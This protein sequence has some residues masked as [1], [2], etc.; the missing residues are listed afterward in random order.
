[1][2]K[3][4][5]QFSIRSP[6]GPHRRLWVADSWWGLSWRLGASQS[7]SALSAFYGLRW[8]EDS[9]TNMSPGKCY[10]YFTKCYF[11]KYTALF[12]QST[13]ESK[14]TKGCRNR[15]PK[16]CKSSGGFT[17][18]GLAKN[19]YFY[20]D[21]QWKENGACWEEAVIRSSRNLSGWRRI[22]HPD[23]DDVHL[24]SHQE[25]VQNHQQSRDAEP[26]MLWSN[27]E[28]RELPQLDGLCD[29][30]QHPVDEE[31]CDTESVKAGESL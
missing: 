27:A 24:H 26:Q 1:M 19:T 10:C 31:D 6:S 23:S 4:W 12:R 25:P 8:W 30:R 21:K 20:K 17:F 5:I 3:K 28:L 22:T 7:S 2:G 15:T 13:L 18:W 16:S 14:L 29:E 9:S 11:H